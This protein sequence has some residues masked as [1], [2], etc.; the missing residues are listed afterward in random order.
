MYA[1]LLELKIAIKGHYILQG[2]LYALRA[3]QL[4]DFFLVQLD[5]FSSLSLLLS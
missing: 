5:I 3:F 4:L 1:L 2:Y